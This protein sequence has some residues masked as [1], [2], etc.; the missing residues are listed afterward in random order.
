MGYSSSLQRYI[1]KRHLKNHA[2]KSI[3][4]CDSIQI[5]R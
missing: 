3:F 1:K 4:R 2:D 5:I